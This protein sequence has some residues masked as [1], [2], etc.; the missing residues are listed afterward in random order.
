MPKQKPAVELVVSGLEQPGRLD[1]FLRHRFPQWGRQAVDTL[2][3]SRKVYVNDRLVWLG[4]WQVENG[5]RLALF[6]QPEAKPQAPTTF[7]DHWLIAVVDEL[8]VVNK[9]AGLLS[10]A[11]RHGQ[12]GNLLDL[13]RQRFGPV[14]LFHRLDRDTSGVILLT[15]PGPINQYLDQVF[16]DRQVEKGY[17]AVVAAG[18]Q[19]EHE[20]VIS[21]RIGSHPLRRDMMAVVERGGKPAVTRYQVIAEQAGRQWLKLW[22]ETGRTH[23]LRV[24]LAWLEAPILGDRLYGRDWHQVE[25]LMLHAHQISLPPFDGY[26]AR[27]FK[28]PLPPDFLGSDLLPG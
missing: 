24:H 26:P 9:P 15:R 27:N 11:P 19:L 18:N 23:Q 1:R 8:I 2:I 4:S 21:A 12:Q 7:D 20:G 3:S 17:L 16:Q 14:T 25:R 5:D 22:P 10:E 28:A 6:E 13:A